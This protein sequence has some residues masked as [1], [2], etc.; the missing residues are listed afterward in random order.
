MY[1]IILTA[2]PTPAAIGA[3]DVAGASVLV[4]VNHN[5]QA[6]AE[7][8]AQALVMHDGWLIG[9]VEEVYWI[10]PEQIAGLKKDIA[11][12]CERALLP[13][14]AALYVA[15]ASDGRPEDY[16]VEFR[17]L[18]VPPGSGSQN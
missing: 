9:E 2:T 15:W 1:L 5:D 6:A 11:G 12:L 3:G 14:A 4:A 7:A 18:P 17:V 8:T 10:D 16:P 13:G